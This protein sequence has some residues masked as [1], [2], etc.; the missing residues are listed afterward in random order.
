MKKALWATALII[1]AS[2]S[3]HANAADKGGLGGNCCVDLEERIA[4]L[5]AVTAKKGNRKMALTVYGQV[6]MAMIWWDDVDYDQIGG[7]STSQTRFGFKGKAPIRK[8]WHAGFVLELGAGLN[9]A[10]LETGGAHDA[11]EFRQSFVYMETPAGTVGLGLQPSAA[12]GITNITMAN[13][14]VAAKMLNLEPVSG[15]FLDDI[16]PNNL[17]FL[18]NDR[19]DQVVKYTSPDLAGFKASASWGNDDTWD[20]ALRYAGEFGG[21]RIAAGV[22]HQDHT[23]TIFGTEFANRVT[24]GSA[25][26]MHTPSGLFVSGA[27]GHFEGDI[28]F[29]YLGTPVLPLTDLTLKAWHAQGGI[30][31]KFFQIGKTTLFA[32][33]GEMDIDGVDVTP[34]L[35]GGGAIQHIDAAAMD[36]YVTFRELDVGID[37]IDAAQVVT[38]GARV[39]F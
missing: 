36:L 39:K 18:S 5:E 31:H 32:E 29:D 25:S 16:R 35:W 6:N 20:V 26:V 37:G 15:R 34:T 30:E 38:A 27:Y 3:W 17:P 24:A 10:T 14:G 12:R 23:R 19:F 33:Y 21:V 11:L 13:T 9:R 28:V 1:G 2:L 4:E 8:G 22:G 7:N